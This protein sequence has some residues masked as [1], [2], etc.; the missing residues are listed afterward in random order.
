M[1]LIAFGESTVAGA[2][3]PDHQGWIGRALKGR[4]DVTLYNL[5]IRGAT[6]TQLAGLWRREAEA[7]LTEEEP[8]R[9]VFGFGVNDSWVENGAPVVTAAQ[10]LLNTRAM[11]TAAGALA[12]VLMVGPTPLADPGRS[13]RVEALN[14]SFKQLCARLQTPFIDVY[15][16]LAADGLWL[17]EARAF[18]GAHPGGAGYQRLADLVAAHPAWRS[19]MAVR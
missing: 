11:L 8:C 5:G 10:S 9:I 19:F 7:R 18:D 13:A 14:E 2:G 17:D 3:D 1:R 6:S 15:R 16:P 4:R 12:P